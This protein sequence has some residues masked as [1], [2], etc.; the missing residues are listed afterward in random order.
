MKFGIL[1]FHKNITKL[2]KKSWIIKFINS[3]NNQ[4]YKNFDIIELNY[5]E[6]EKIKLFKNSDYY[7]KSFNNHYESL[8]YLLD[9]SFNIKKYDY[10]MITNID[11]FY[12]EN[13]ILYS[14]KE[15]KNNNYD[16]ISN[17][18][19]LYQSI[20][21]NDFK[22]EVQ[23]VPNNINSDFNINWHILHNIEKNKNIIENSGLIISNKFYKENE[24]YYDIKKSPLS[25][26]NIWKKNIKINT[27]IHI[28][29]KPL[30]YQRIHENQYINNFRN[31]NLI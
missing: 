10:V 8:N 23:L 25:I 30:T 7:C 17:N 18:I 3:I 1:V 5:D 26:L 22:R 15:I 28:I 4:T 9:L 14:I 19:Y 2:Y 16:I 24:I 12:N 31:S 11:D 13:K 29:N 6:N 20:K 21:N 27:K